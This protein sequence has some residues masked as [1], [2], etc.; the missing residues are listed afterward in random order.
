MY[1]PDYEV[2]GQMSLFDDDAKAR[3]KPGRRFVVRGLEFEVV[4]VE[5]GTVFI[6][7][8]KAKKTFTYG[9]DALIRID[10]LSWR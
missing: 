1:P 10:G 9:L 7:E 3:V 2:D 5:K 4:T 8:L 6:R